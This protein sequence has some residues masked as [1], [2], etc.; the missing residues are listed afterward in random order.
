MVVGAVI[1]GLFDALFYP[2]S[3]ALLPD[4]VTGEHLTASNSLNRILGNTGRADCS[5]PLVGGVIASTIGVSW[6]LVIDASTFVV[7]AGLSARH[8]NDAATAPRVRLDGWLTSARGWPIVGAPR[9]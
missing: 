5:G 2:A 6:S 8:A 1:F 3:T 7:S 9:G 4:V